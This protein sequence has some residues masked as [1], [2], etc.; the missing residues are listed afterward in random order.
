MIRW[1]SAI[2]REWHR[3]LRDVLGAKTADQFAKLGVNTVGDLMT[4][5][6]RRY[7]PGTQMSDFATLRV[8]EHTAVVAQVERVNVRAGQRARVEVMLSDGSRYLQAT[9]F[10]PR[11]YLV[12]FWTA[13]LKRGAR[14]IFVG[15][16]G[17]FRD[18]LQLAHPDFVMLDGARIT[19]GSRKLTEKQQL[20]ADKRAAMERTLQRATMIGLYPASAKLP[21]WIIAESVELVLPGVMGLGDTLPAWV[22]RQA[23]V[24]PL[25]EALSAV[26]EPVEA[27]TAWA[28]VHRLRFDEAFGMQLAMVHRRATLSHR[29]AV[30]RRRIAGGALDEFDARLPFTLTR[31]QLAVGEEIFDELARPQPMN[32]LL[33]G[34]VGSGKTLVALRAML[35]VVDAGGQAAM[36]APTEVLA[37]QHH[38][39]IVRM[40]GDLGAGQTLGA[41]PSATGVAL[42]VGSLTAAQKRDALQRI[43][44]GE[45]GIVVGTHALLSE[46]VEFTDLGLVVV[47]EQHRFGVEQRALLSEKSVSQPHTLIM[48]A[49]PIPRSLAITVFGDLAVS[50]L[51]EKPANRAEV[52]TVF[53]NTETHPTWVER[54]WQRIREE[55][56]AGRQAFIVCPAITGRQAED[57]TSAGK[58]MTAVTELL[59]ELADGP[60]RGL[61][62]GMVHGKQPADERDEVM[63]RFVA[64]ELDVLISTTVIEVGVDVP[65]ASVM[66]VMDAE[67]FGISQLHQ[68]RGRIGRGE[69][70]GLCLLLGNPQEETIG[71]ERMQ[72]LV[73]SHDG[74]E[75]AE[76]DL[77]LRREG[78]V[79]G[80]AQSGRS[81]LKL[82]RVLA[83]RTLIEQARVLAEQVFADP[84][85]SED[86]LLADVIAHAELLAAGEWLERT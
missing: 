2:H 66:V 81:S 15:K 31:G 13:Q 63:G 22:V 38:D 64:G 45:A 18:Q 74:F 25:P 58:G 75:L 5:T 43:A 36:L 29:E 48:T 73:D 4:H 51:T 28:G 8:G 60:L 17:V 35:A 19:G 62:L 79:L 61:R 39:T 69:H 34:D 20:N 76:K 11:P 33:Q 67:R 84:R 24:L 14:G 56:A 52:D 86:P 9:F 71:V 54:A 72:A 32:R 78:D 59:P 21:T 41:H 7:I 12:E 27:K 40:L 57:G 53:V 16:V 80:A 47:D 3:N 83:D 26:H 46:G 37:K 55:V 42:L 77:E 49:T 44:S 85:S 1:Q 50:E 23:G 30:P 65:N 6:P 68:L 82:L 10:A 70:P